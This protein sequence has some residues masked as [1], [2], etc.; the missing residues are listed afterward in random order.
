[1]KNLICA[2]LLLAFLFSLASCGSDDESNPTEATLNHDGPNEFAP[3]LLAGDYEA[4]AAFRSAETSQYT[5]WEIYEVEVFIRFLPDYASLTIYG[6]GDAMSPGTVLGTQTI[7]SLM[8]EQWNTITLDQPVAISGNDL[9]VAV[10]FGHTASEAVIGCDP[11]PAV[12]DGQWLYDASTQTWEVVR[13][14]INWNIRAKI[15]QA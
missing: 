4:A 5:G 3:T 14:N 9:W 7:P 13:I 8:P 11:G 15:R 12:T 6:A 2:S 1:M 10:S